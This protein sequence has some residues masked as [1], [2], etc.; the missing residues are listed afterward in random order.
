V[1]LTEDQVGT[2]GGANAA[3]DY[4]TLVEQIP[5]IT[6]T[7]I[8]DPR[9]PSG[10][11]TF[12][13]PQATRI[14]GHTPQEFLDDPE[15]WRKLRHPGDRATV[16]AAERTADVTKRPFHAEYR[17]HDRAGKLHWFRDDAVIVDHTGSGGTFWQGV[18]F[19]V[20]AEKEAEQQAREADRRYRSLVESLPC[21]VYVDQLDERATN[22][23]TSPQTESLL[24]YTK[25]DWA[26][27]PDL[28]ASKILEPADRERLLAAERY[29]AET[30]EPF[31]EV[32]RAVHRD[33]HTVWLRDVAV[34]VHDED[35]IPLYSQG[36]LIDITP[37]KEAESGLQ[38]ALD[39][40]HSQA[41]ELRRMDD[42]K[43]T[44]LHT[45]SHDLKGPITAVL[46]STAA[47]KREDIGEA[48]RRELLDGMAKRVR[49]MDRLLTD[50]LDLERIGRGIIE[51]VT[52]PVDLGQLVSDLVHGTDVLEGRSVE[53]TARPVVAHVDPPK[54]ERIVENLLVNAVRHT[55][56][57]TKVW[58]R[59][60]PQEGGALI[61]VEDAGAGIPAADKQ[62]VFEAFRKG[63]V[64]SPGSGIGLSL[65]ARFAELHGG[66]AWV[67]DRPGGGSSFRV[68]LPG[69]RPGPRPAS[70]AD[71]AVAP[72]HEPPR[73]A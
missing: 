40:E 51:P 70:R 59:V 62:D 31:D 53:V 63:N 60:A 47:L 17:M 34:V 21:V 52:F 64:D 30:G 2:D 19:D 73:D 27:E 1:A 56:A 55:P 16:M 11:P 33:G 10:R 39:R 22:V 26:A 35:G 5:A 43:N 28:W 69:P 72:E 66:R 29:H 3:V 36:F 23:Y 9:M 25:D 67:Q 18:M 13:S 41:D 42:L 57:G 24:G 58:V 44:L 8:H 38:E 68:F 46:A 20:T 15:L 37:Q 48:D 4:R 6:Y 12:V 61:C 7:E 50:L 49:K 65:V 54:I 71:H 14:L 32:Y 45:L